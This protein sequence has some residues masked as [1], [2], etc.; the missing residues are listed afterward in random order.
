MRNRREF[1]VDMVRT[2]SL[3]AVPPSV[4]VAMATRQGAVD[5]HAHVFLHTLAMAEHHR[6]VPD[7][8]AP[9][10]EYLGLLDRY[11]MTNGVLVQ[12]SF[13]GTDNSFMLAC[14]RAHPE[15]LRCIA[16]INPATDLHAL[17]DMNS[18][19]CVGIRLNLIGL[20]DPQLAGEIWQTAL[21][22]LREMDWLVEVQAE[23]SRLEHTM[24]PLLEAG[25]RVVVD[26]FGRPDPV[27]GVDDP[28]F[29]YLLSTGSTGRVSVK[30][31]GA[32]RNGDH[33][34]GEE[35]AG[36]AMPLLRKTFGLQQIVWGSDWPHTQFE[37][38]TSYEAA[39]R[40][41]LKLLPREQD[42]H[43]VLWESASRLFG[44]TRAWTAHAPV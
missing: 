29:Q 35:I 2:L 22:K 20:P 23:A 14:V 10:S 1:I 43:I 16:V 12:P 44:F 8:D 21:T 38:K 6:Y 31:S 13:L 26:H 34:R 4:A 15:R 27:T 33:G 36:Q 5:S 3:T 40:L 7:Y 19:G 42:R 28:G 9:L 39:Y 32:Y 41:L 25:V 11:G 30:I 37:K 18:V 17:D 24:K